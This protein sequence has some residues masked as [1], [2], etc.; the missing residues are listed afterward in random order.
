M[1]D[2]ICDIKTSLFREYQSASQAYSAAVS[3]LTHKVTEA[4]PIEYKRLCFTAK[5]ARKRTREA[6]NG[7]EVHTLEHGC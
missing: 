3:K 2:P 4:S 1:H 7:L 6:K 5:E